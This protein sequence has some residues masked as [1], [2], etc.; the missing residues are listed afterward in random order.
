M[1]WIFSIYS[2]F[3]RVPFKFYFHLRDGFTECDSNLLFN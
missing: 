3:Y 1:S 2:T